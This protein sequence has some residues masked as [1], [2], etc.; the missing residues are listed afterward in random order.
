MTKKKDTEKKGK[1]SIYKNFS[2]KLAG[3]TWKVRFETP[4]IASEPNV[5][6]CGLCDRDNA[7]ITVQPNLSPDTVIITLY[8]ELY[9]AYT[10]H[11]DTPEGNVDIEMAADSV[12][13]GQREVTPQLLKKAPWLFEVKK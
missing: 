1:E 8:H 11:I 9:H 2:F 4:V 12:G 6:L 7:V 10:R 3:R 5:Q 13:E